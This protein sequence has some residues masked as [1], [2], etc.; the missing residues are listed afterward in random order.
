MEVMRF[1][2]LASAVGSE[3]VSFSLNQPVHAG[4]KTPIL[5]E[6]ATSLGG[7]QRRS[8][9]KACVAQAFWSHSALAA[10]D[11][12][13]PVSY[14]QCAIAPLMIWP[15][16]SLDNMPNSITISCCTCM[17]GTASTCI[18]STKAAVCSQVDPSPGQK[19]V[20]EHAAQLCLV[21]KQRPPPLITSTPPLQVL[22]AAWN[23]SSWQFVPVASVAT[24]QK[25]NLNL[26]SQ[27]PCL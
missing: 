15:E 26:M 13:N 12:G 17:Y 23:C 18:C 8:D 14:T 9:C 11:P 6:R 2:A 10:V 16:A 4:L 22:N 20:P 24:P 27:P 1:L 7:S 21:L 3:S 19:Q 25:Q 5:S